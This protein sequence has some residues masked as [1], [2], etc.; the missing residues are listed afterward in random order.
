M[1]AC[2]NFQMIAGQLYHFCQDGVL[3]LVVCPD[4]YPGIL[5]QAHVSIN[6]YHSSGE[7]T[8][9]RILREGFWWPTLKEDVV[10]HVLQCHKCRT[11]RPNEHYALF[12]VQPIPSWVD[13]IYQFTSNPKAFESLPLHCHKHLKEESKKYAIIGNQLYGRGLDGQLRL[14][15]C[16]DEYIPVLQCVHSA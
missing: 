16:E 6:G 4:D 10:T 11:S 7:L 15:V 8:M 13:K 9:Q 1:Q 14:C 3:R 2:S 12:H 5:H